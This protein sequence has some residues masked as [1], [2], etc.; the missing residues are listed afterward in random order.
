MAEQRE[1]ELIFEPQEEGGYHVYAPD[2]PGLNSQGDTLAE[3]EAN[4]Q[5]ALQLYVEALREDGRT[6]ESAVIRRRY[7]LPV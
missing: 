3:A 1:V 7:P 2:L 6:V 5:E 4:A